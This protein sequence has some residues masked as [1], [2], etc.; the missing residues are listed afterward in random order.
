MDI[1]HG[2]VFAVW[3]KAVIVVVYHVCAIAK[4]DE[5]SGGCSRLSQ[6]LPCDHSR[7]GSL[8]SA[9]TDSRM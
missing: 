2:V 5:D 9:S 7:I 1:Y 6:R 3:T 8:S 4:I